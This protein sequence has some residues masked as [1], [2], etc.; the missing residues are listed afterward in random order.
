M[1]SSI[2]LASFALFGFHSENGCGI[3]EEPCAEVLCDLYCENGYQQDENGCDTCS[4]NPPIECEGL[5][6]AACNDNAACV[7]DYGNICP[8]ILCAPDGDCPPC[9]PDEFL[10]CRDRLPCEGLDEASCSDDPECRPIYSSACDAICE[11]DNCLRAPCQSE[12]IGCEVRR[13]EGLDENACLSD[14]SCR[15]RYEEA[16]CTLECRPDPNDPTNCLPCDPISIYA[17]CEENTGCAAKDEAACNADP[18]CVADYGAICAAVICDAADP[19]DCPPCGPDQFLGCRDRDPCEGLDENACN[20]D[21]SCWAEYEALACTTECRP[22]P[23]DPEGCLPCDP[24]AVFVA[25]HSHW[26]GT[27]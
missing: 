23:N 24:V 14:P 25:C 21:P 22:D 8:L 26:C 15:P 19:I 7:A 2:V 4:C 6:E 10:G 16:V 3:G 13:C 12:Y 9:G 1:R 5:D 17:G 20:A 18:S 11:G 27:R